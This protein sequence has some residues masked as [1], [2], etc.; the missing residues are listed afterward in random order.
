M[1]NYN[2]QLQMAQT[3]G[4][5]AKAGRG[6]RVD[7]DKTLPSERIKDGAEAADGQVISSGNSARDYRK[8][9]KK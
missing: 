9:N 3:S 5:A 1:A 2:L 7:E 6:M 4:D 8:K